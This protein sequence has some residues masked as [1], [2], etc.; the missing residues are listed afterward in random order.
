[1]PAEGPKSTGFR[2]QAKW[3]RPHKVHFTPSDVRGKRKTAQ[4][5]PTP[6][7]A[8]LSGGP[9]FRGHGALGHGAW[10]HRA[11]LLEMWAHVGLL[12]ML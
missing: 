8:P 10:A 4:L 9:S 5:G 11:L 1:M 12:G 7:P 6:A 3:D 2:T